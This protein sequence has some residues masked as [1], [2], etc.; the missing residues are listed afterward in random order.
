MTLICDL[1]IFEVRKPLL[2][3]ENLPKVEFW[4]KYL[5]QVDRLVA[6]SGWHLK[7]KIND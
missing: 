1:P 2:D 7:L 4:G 3:Q 6:T 5:Y